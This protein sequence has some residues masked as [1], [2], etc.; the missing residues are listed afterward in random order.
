MNLVICYKKMSGVLVG[1]GRPSCE[2]KKIS[3]LL[4]TY[5]RF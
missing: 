3:L 1:L 2:F 4:G 5:Y